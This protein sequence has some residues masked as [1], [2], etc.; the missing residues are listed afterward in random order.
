[1]TEATGASP[2]YLVTGA[3]GFVGSHLVRHLAA[4]GQ[5]LR[6]MVRKPEQAEPLRD[7]VEEVV[8]AD[9]QKPDTLNAAVAGVHGIYHIAALF[10]TAGVPDSAFDEVNVQ[11]V[12]NILDAA[13][14]AGVKRFVHCSTNGVHSHI[15]NPPADETA[16]FNP[17]DAY[18]VSKLEGE[19]I[20][21]S[22]FE[23]EK[24]RGVIIRPAMIYG[25]GDTRILKLFKMV[26]NGKFFYIGRG[27]ALT[28]WLDVRDLARAFELGMLKDELNAEAFLIAGK[29]Y[30]TLKQDVHQIAKALEVPEPKLHLPV[31]PIMALAHVT[32]AVCK[33]FGIEPP[34]FPRRVSFFLKN[35]AFDISKARKLLGYEPRTD[36]A[37]EIVDIIAAYRA[38]GDLPPPAKQAA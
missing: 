31:G 4:Q 27:E 36:F 29:E 6:I 9:L 10:R 32:E 35:R 24:I 19:K 16:P 2:L 17:S 12:R 1:M 14:A 22:C 15:A 21:M 13:I 5:R 20:V 3:A 37:G 26:A 30:S 38:S 7:L 11:G 23:Q 18:Q 8:I 33:P 25:P 34:L 28:H